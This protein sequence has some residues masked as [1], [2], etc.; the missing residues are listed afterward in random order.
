MIELT[1]LCIDELMKGSQFYEQ[2]FLLKYKWYLFQQKAFFKQPACMA[3]NKRD[4]K[5]ELSF[6]FDWSFILFVCLYNVTRT[7]Q[8]DIFNLLWLFL[9]FLTE[10]LP[11]FWMLKAVPQKW[12]TL[13]CIQQQI[14]E[15]QKKLSFPQKERIHESILRSNYFMH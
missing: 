3:S 6:L 15:T 9:V 10:N 13:I 11:L 5:Y 1:F 2:E 4:K 14:P 12:F 7:I 8:H